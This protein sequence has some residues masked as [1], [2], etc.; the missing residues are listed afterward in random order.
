VIGKRVTVLGTGRMGAA[1]VAA[2]RRA[3]LDVMVWN[4]TSSKAEEVAGVTGAKT[5]G[6]PAEAAAE[7][8]VVVSSLADDEAVLETYA[9]DRGAASGLRAGAVACEMSTIMPNTVRELRPLIEGRD[10]ALVDAPVSGS[11]AF[12]EAGELTLMVGGEDAALES[13]RPVLE[14]LSAKLFHV[15]G[16]GAG[17]TMKLAVNTLVHGLN[18]ALSEALV[19]AEKAGVDRHTAYDV[20]AAGAGGAPFVHYKRAAFES[21]DETPVAFA[22]DLMIKDLDLILALADESGVMMDQARA[23]RSLAGKAAEVGLG[24]KDMSAIA[25][26]LRER[27]T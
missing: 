8:D 18:V 9:G 21:P 15:G 27:P 19:L 3:G 22:V 7:A 11:V 2:L 4:R 1:M 16:L 20:F 10:A 12:A 17:A 25:V 5:A 6:T 26:F 23:N 13:A 24:K 14:T